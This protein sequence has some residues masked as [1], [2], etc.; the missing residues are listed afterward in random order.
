MKSNIEIFDKN[1]KAL[2]IGSVIGRFLNEQ[3]EQIGEMYDIEDFTI[4]LENFFDDEGKQMLCIY[5]TEY[6]ILD[7]EYVNA[8]NPVN[9]KT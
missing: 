4:G 2:H 5:D 7:S 9:D 1:G 6:V 8:T 3:N